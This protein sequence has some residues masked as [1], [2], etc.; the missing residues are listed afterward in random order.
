M[1]IS[2]Q[3]RAA[4]ALLAAM[5]WLASAGEP[6][7]VSYS[8]PLVLLRDD[9]ANAASKPTADDRAS[10]VF[11]AFGRRFALNL[12]PNRTLTGTAQ[13]GHVYR[14]TIAGMPGSWAR[15]TLSGGVPQ[16]L[17]YDGNELIAIERRPG[18]ADGPPLVFRLADMHIEPGALRCGVHDHVRTAAELMTGM[19]TAKT[20]PAVAEA[21][22][23]TSV[24][25]VGVLADSRYTA[26]PLSSKQDSILTR[27]N[28][29][30]GIFSDQLGV[31]IDVERIDIF[32]SASDPFTGETDATALLNEVGNY[33]AN[34]PAQNSLG[35]THLFTGRDLDGATK[36]IAFLDVLCSFRFGV[37]LTQ[38]SFGITTDSLIAA[39]EFG[40]N[41]SAPH[42]AE[43]GT[44]CE[45]T[46]STF[47]MAPSISGSDQFS[48]CS[49]SII[50]PAIS[51]AACITPRLALDV[52]IEES[53][54][55]EPVLFGETATLRYSVLNAGTIDADD[56]TV[57]IPL[58]GDTLVSISATV[59]SCSGGA[60]VA[61]CSLG[62]IAPGDGATITLDV[63]PNRTDSVGYEATV[64]APGDE[65]PANDAA[66]ARVTVDPV[67]DVS[68]TAPGA[69]VLVDSRITI[70]PVVS[71]AGAQT[72][73]QLSVTITPGAGLRIDGVRWQQGVCS[74]V[75]NAV[76]CEGGSLPVSSSQI[77][78][79]LT[80][81]STGDKSYT[82]TAQSSTTDTDTGN[83]TASG[84][85][86]VTATVPSSG[87]GGSGGG[88]AAGLGWL[89]IL[90]GGVL[91][92]RVRARSSG[93]AR[94]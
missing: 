61:Q 80:G 13:N 19:A 56:V 44:A 63:V 78:L 31:E 1:R 22:G 84:T 27:M 90:A 73:R 85:V 43:S 79:D 40:H 89:A 14:G 87:G 26:D 76:T 51:R 33:R 37:G 2:V 93:S 6:I 12:T 9:A 72:A 24:L 68:V 41:F 29:V 60:D 81:L 59:G 15:V 50:E 45:S 70:S 21:A 16:G 58:S 20:A 34:T 54:E 28:I 92:R 66:T 48:D 18:A 8:E 71:N 23:A 82:I 25:Q 32:D 64:A 39:H 38:S 10:V 57:A 47:L 62:R 11:D 65:N 77:S 88:G 42:D 55:A 7:H 83:N 74:L 91:L 69:S 46:P 35:L 4:V 3:R 67:A 94:V 17:L 5:P 53:G 36:G 30:D 86:R 49:I 75:D 52:A